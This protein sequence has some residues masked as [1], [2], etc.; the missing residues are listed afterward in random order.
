[1][2]EMMVKKAEK[3]IIITHKVHGWDSCYQIGE[4]ENPFFVCRFLVS[5]E[6][7]MRLSNLVLMACFKCLSDIQLC[8]CLS[9]LPFMWYS[10]LHLGDGRGLAK[11]E[12]LQVGVENGYL[13]MMCLFFLVSC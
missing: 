13:P 6:A 11:V 2:L 4:M 9:P 3:R 1:M 8:V 12:R 5:R 7:G 10:K